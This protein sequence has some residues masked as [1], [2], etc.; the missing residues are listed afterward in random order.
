MPKITELLSSSTEFFFFFLIIFVL[1]FRYSWFTVFC[2]FSTVQQFFKAGMGVV[3][4][5]VSTS[6]SHLGNWCTDLA[7]SAQACLS[8]NCLHNYSCLCQNWRASLKCWVQPDFP[9][10]PSTHI[11]DNNENCVVGICVKSF[12][13]QIEYSYAFR[14][15]SKSNT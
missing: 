9:L 8:L 5:S 7:I 1:F 4:H 14:A 12:K 2:E 3:C 6:Q 11:I 10:L 15:L 13:V